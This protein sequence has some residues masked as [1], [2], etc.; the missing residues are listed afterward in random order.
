MDKKAIGPSKISRG[1]TS[2]DLGTRPVQNLE[3]GVRSLIFEGCALGK[4]KEGG[5]K[6]TRHLG[7]LKRKSPKLSQ[8]MVEIKGGV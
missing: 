6:Q 2:V 7:F 1:S 3:G 8:A 4:A 5:D